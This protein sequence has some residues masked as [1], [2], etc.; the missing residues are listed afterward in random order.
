MV[1]ERATLAGRGATKRT[2]PSR[3]GSRVRGGLRVSL[4]LEGFPSI[5][6]HAR[7]S[8]RARPAW[9]SQPSLQDLGSGERGRGRGHG[10]AGRGHCVFGWGSSGMRVWKK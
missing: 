1:Q 3:A 8:D 9:P 7:G 5:L 6:H 4:G 2:R 10:G